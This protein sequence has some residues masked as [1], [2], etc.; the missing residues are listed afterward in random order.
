M[1]LFLVF[2]QEWRVIILSVTVSW[3]AC[4]LLARALALS[5]TQ[6]IRLGETTHRKHDYAKYHAEKY[7]QRATMCGPIWL[8]R[9]LLFQIKVKLNRTFGA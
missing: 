1:N 7:V 4:S 9:V 6:E 8:L 3:V 5:W 2:L